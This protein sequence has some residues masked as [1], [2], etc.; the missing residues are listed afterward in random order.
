M[1]KPREVQAMKKSE[2]LIRM[3]EFCKN[4]CPVCTRARRRGKGLLYAL[5]KLERRLCPYCRA[6]EK[7]YG[8]PAYR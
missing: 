6:Y 1:S 3:A 2:R 5:V 7:V 8:K 4:Q